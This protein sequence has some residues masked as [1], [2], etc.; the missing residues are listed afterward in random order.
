MFFLFVHN[1]SQMTEFGSP[2]SHAGPGRPEALAFWYMIYLLIDIFFEPREEEGVFGLGKIRKRS[3]G[4]SD[5]PVAFF[6]VPRS[7]LV[8]GRVHFDAHSLESCL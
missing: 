5:I 4:R 7:F 2:R 1:T 3:D 8:M 6:F